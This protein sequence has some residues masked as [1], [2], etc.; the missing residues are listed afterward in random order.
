MYH[1][2]SVVLIIPARNEAPALSSVL[3]RIPPFIDKV[4]VVDNGST[5]ATPRIARAHGALVVAE[6]C[7]GYGRACL[8]ALTM[9]RENPPDIVAFADADGS[10]DFS[11][12]DELLAPLANDSTD[13]MLGSRDPVDREAFS[14]Q[15]RIGNR[16]ITRLIALIWRH[17]YADLG[18]MRAITWPALQCLNMNDK[19]YGWTVEMQIRALTRGLRVRELPVPYRKRIAGQSKVSRSLSGS[20]KAGLKMLWVVLREAIQSFPRMRRKVHST[21]SSGAV[22]S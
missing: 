2:K 8:A 3:T 10:D 21:C 4:I 11:A 16:M 22:K 7:A 9:L 18:P 20:L 15:Q 13:L 14:W 6:P 19:N 5:D 12:L 1:G 17:S